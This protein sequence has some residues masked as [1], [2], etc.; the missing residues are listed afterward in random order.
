MVFRPPDKQPDIENLEISLVNSK[1][2]QKNPALFDTIR[3][4]IQRVRQFQ[5]LVVNDITSINESIAALTN[6]VNNINIAAVV[7]NPV[8]IMP[9]IEGMD[10]EEGFI[11]PGPRGRDGLDGKTIF[12]PNEYDEPIESA[13]LFPQPYS[14]QASEVTFTTTGNIDDL[15]FSNVQLIRFNNAT[16]TTLRGLKAGKAG[17]IVIIISVG[18]GHVYLDNENAGSIAANRLTNSISSG[19]TPLAAGAG[20]CVY[21]YN[22][23]GQ[24]WKLVS[25]DQGQFIDIPHGSTTYDSDAGAFWTVDAADVTTQKILI[26][27]RQALVICGYAN[28]TTLLGVGSRLRADFSG[29]KTWTWQVTT[30]NWARVNQAGVSANGMVTCGG[31][32]SRIQFSPD[33]TDPAWGVGA[34]NRGIDGATVLLG[35]T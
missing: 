13:P 24:R 6:V 17:Q 23:T 4:L 7:T 33:V 31:A 15:D 12:F 20:K 19:P 28:T 30:R 29:F 35:V 32:S 9:V 21:Q 26:V 34:N 25:H 22:G 14:E 11:I 1:L 16:D 2:Q 8:A 18:A 5:G 27:G 10:G 3:G